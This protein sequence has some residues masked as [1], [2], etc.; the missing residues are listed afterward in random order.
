MTL[1][2]SDPSPGSA[3]H[4]SPVLFVN[5]ALMVML[6]ALSMRAVAIDIAVGQVTLNTPILPSVSFT[7]VNFAQTYSTP[8]LVFVM[9]TDDTASEAS[10]RIR[11]VTTTSF[12][13]AHVIPDGSAFGWPSMTIDYIAIEPGTHTI[14]GVTVDAGFVDTTRIQSKFG[15]ASWETVAFGATL[16]NTPA[17]LSQIQTMAN[18]TPD[19]TTPSSPWMT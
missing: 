4:P 11:N 8:P 14:G 2:L 13:V 17:V 10:L 16:S 19:L 7:S 15:G 5:I 6:C 18:E 9:P 3:R 12:E 1:L